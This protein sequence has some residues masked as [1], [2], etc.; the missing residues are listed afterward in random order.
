M[1]LTV[2]PPPFLIRREIFFPDRQEAKQKRRRSPDERTTGS[3]ARYVHPLVHQYLSTSLNRYLNMYTQMCTYIKCICVLVYRHMHA[4]A[5]AL[6]MHKQTAVGRMKKSLLG[7][8]IVSEDTGNLVPVMRE[9]RREE[10]P[11]SPHICKG[12]PRT[13]HISDSEQSIASTYPATDLSL[14]LPFRCLS[15][16]LSLAIFPARSVYL[17]RSSYL[18]TLLYLPI[19]C[20]SIYRFICL[21]RSIH[22]HVSL[23]LSRYLSIYLSCSTYL[24][25]H[26]AL[27]I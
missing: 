2:R 22:L 16:L 23:Y 19:Y 12:R 27:P 11:L 1:K 15:N 21:A 17:A 20:C 10:L 8:S 14:C 26:L 25:I 9:R 13:Y 18:S 4:A 3:H 5:P 7:P 24:A 6:D